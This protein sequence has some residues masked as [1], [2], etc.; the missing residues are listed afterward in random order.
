MLFVALHTNTDWFNF[1]PDNVETAASVLKA[2]GGGSRLDAAVDFTGQKDV[3]EKAIHALEV[4]R[5]Q[6]SQD[7]ALRM[8]SYIGI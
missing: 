3:L 1:H 6:I 2:A 8:V 5:I 7:L 4:V